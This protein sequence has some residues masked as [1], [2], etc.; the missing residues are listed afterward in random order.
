MLSLRRGL[1]SQ[2]A[3]G[4]WLQ[5]RDSE[6]RLEADQG[7]GLI[8]QKGFGPKRAPETHPKLLQSN[9]SLSSVCFARRGDGGRVAPALLNR[10][11]DG[12]RTHGVI[13]MLCPLIFK[14]LLV[15]VRLGVDD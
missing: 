1:A 3:V 8:G 4:A 10:L 15:D 2:L 5:R 11:K 9:Q 14:R 12:L 13:L 7:Q 6:R